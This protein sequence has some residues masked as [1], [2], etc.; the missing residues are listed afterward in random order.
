[1]ISICFR[2]KDVENTDTE[3]HNS[4]TRFV[5]QP[6]N[7]FTFVSRWIHALNFI[8]GFFNFI[9]N[10]LDKYYSMKPFKTVE[11]LNDIELRCIAKD[12]TEKQINDFDNIQVTENALNQALNHILKNIIKGNYESVLQMKFADYGL[13]PS[14][15]DPHRP[16]SFLSD[17]F[18]D[19]DP[20]QQNV[21]TFI[22]LFIGVSALK[23]FIRLN[24]IGPLDSSVTYNLVSELLPDSEISDSVIISDGL[25]IN[26]MTIY[27]NIFKPKLLFM[28]NMIFHRLHCA[29]TTVPSI[30]SVFWYLRCTF[31]H[32][33]LIPERS[34]VSHDLIINLIKKVQDMDWILKDDNLL[35]KLIFAVE[36]CHIFLYYG[37]ITQS[38]KHLEVAQN[39]TGLEIELSGAMGKRTQYQT[40]AVAQLYVKLKR[41]HCAFSN[42]DQDQMESFPI[43]LHLQDDTLLDRVQFVDSNETVVESLCAEEQI[44]LL[45]CCCLGRKSGSFDELLKEETMSY[46]SCLLSQPK[47]WSVYL[48]ALVIRCKAEKNSSRRMERAVM[49]MEAI[50]ESLKKPSPSFYEREKFF[51]CTSFP[52]YWNLE[53]ELADLL[54]SIGCTKSALE[55]YERLELWED[56]VNC[57]LRLGRTSCAE[58]IVRDQLGKGENAMLYCL[59]GDVTE[60]IEHYKKALNMTEFKSA[61]AHRSLG[62]YFYKRK[63]YKECLSHFS[64]SLSLNHIQPEVWFSLGHAATQA[65]DYKEAAR[66]YREV[67]MFDEDNFQAWNNLA[68]A[69]IKTKQKDRAWRCFQEALKCNYE[70]WRVWE[71][72][73]LVSTDIGAFEDTLRAWHRLLDI[74]G[75]HYDSLLLEILVNAVVKDL[76]DINNCPSSRLKKRTLELLG[77]I[78]SITTNEPKAWELYSV[79]TNSDSEEN[80]QKEIFE[81]VV[82]YQQ[83]AV[84]CYNHKGSWENN[85]ETWKEVVTVTQKLADLYSIYV[86]LLDD[87]TVKSQQKLS[88]RLNLQ[89]VISRA[90]KSIDYFPDCEKT[91]L[92][93]MLNSLQQSITQILDL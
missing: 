24:F 85:I 67:V 7:L 74:K 56:L 2:T 48:K 52:T 16:K 17:F 30:T 46:I 34:Q 89:S 11:E 73:L 68:N 29:G 62:Y 40:K 90:K 78:T 18:K 9:S 64:S 37:D 93:T 3:E 86:K 5:S 22:L 12:F 81:K 36:C 79:L 49:Q 26:E 66:A 10:S 50:V 20:D 83:K 92:E 71:N 51:F 14:K 88:A 87:N 23:E 43:D 55:I 53:K 38:R 42:S 32:Q 41:N 72:F 65:E 57:Y 19:D 58:K 1:M 31:V 75:K 25:R 33:C 13:S 27:C 91:Q 61:R 80:V 39:I 60:N 4:E 47:V 45:A 28:A 54:L 84:R 82:I 35:H 76:P 77:R 15:I 63:E 70:E 6:F 59:L 44:V 69:Y 21:K 8:A